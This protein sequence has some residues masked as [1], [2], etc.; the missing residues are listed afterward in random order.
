MDSVPENLKIRAI[1]QIDACQEIVKDGM[2]EMLE[3]I[4]QA[5]YVVQ[6]KASRSLL[7]HVRDKLQPGY[8]R[9]LNENGP[10]VISRQRV[11]ICLTCLHLD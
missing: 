3:D 1:D 9:V 5:M 8:L 4:Q 11:S 7:P 2:E 6:K 10:G